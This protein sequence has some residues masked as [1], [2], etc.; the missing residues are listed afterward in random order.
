M[1]ALFVGEF[2]GPDVLEWR[3]VPDPAPGPG[4]ALVRTGGFAVNWADVMQRRGKYPGGPAPPF[5]TGHDLMGVVVAHGAGADAPPIGARVFGVLARSGAAA[6]YVAVPAHW[7]HPAPAN[8]TDEQAAGVAS[9]FLTGDAALMTFGRLQPGEAVLVHAAAGG[10]GSATVQ[11]ARAYGAGTVIGT[12]GSDDKLERVGE[13]GVDV[14]V[15]YTTGDFIEPTLEATG[16]RGVDVVVDSVGGE[17]LSDSFDC[18]AP[19]GRLVSV[20]A[21]SLSSSRRFRLH[22]LFEKHVSVAG[23]TLGMMMENHPELVAPMIERVLEELKNETVRPIVGGVFSADRAAE[24][25][26]FMEDRKSVGRT[27]VM[28]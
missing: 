22:T 26:R 6:D 9:P 17:V 5:A 27:I 24:A 4:E 13:W 23:F 15:N 11:L 25:H 1:Q 14:L 21:S 18:L 8:L 2:G 20:G 10:V 3:S 16:G 28:M 19:L 12:A 7:L